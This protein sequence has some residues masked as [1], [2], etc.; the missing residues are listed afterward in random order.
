VTTPPTRRTPNIATGYHT[1]L[2]LK[3]ATD[4]PSFRPYFQQSALDISV[5]YDLTSE[6]ETRSLVLA[7]VNPLTSLSGKRKSGDDFVSKSQFHI[8]MSLGT[9]RV[10]LLCTSSMCSS[11]FE[12]EIGKTSLHGVYT[13]Y[14]KALKSRNQT[15][16]GGH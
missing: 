9:V 15:V 10:S 3:R 12:A 11:L 13:C 1:L 4:W 6:K 8:V 7:F 14:D 16:Y 2:R 5:A